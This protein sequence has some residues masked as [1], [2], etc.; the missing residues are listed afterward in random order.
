MCG[1]YGALVAGLPDA[2]LRER[3]QRTFAN[4]R[5]RG[6]DSWGLVAVT[7]DGT[8]ELGRSPSGEG[9]PDL[10][11]IE[12]TWPLALIGLRRAEPTTEW[13]HA[14]RDAD[15]QPFRSPGGWV[16]CHNGTI[17]NDRALLDQLRYHPDFYEPDTRVDS[18]VIGVALDCLGWQAAI[19]AL[20]GAF[21][22]LAARV[23][24]PGALMFA[25]NY[26]PMFAQGT[27]SGDLIQIASQRHFF[28]P[29]DSPLLDPQP[30]ELPP[31]SIGRVTS[32][33]QL[34]L[35]SLYPRRPERRRVLALCSGGLDCAVAAWKHHVEGDEVTLLH[36]DYGCRAR[37][38]ERAAVERLAERIG[39]AP[40][41][42][43]TD[44]FTRRARS[45]LTAPELEVQA[46]RGGEGAAELGAEWVP[47]RNTVFLAL[48]LAY[49][50]AHDFDTITLG[51]NLEESSGGYPDNEQEFVNKVAELIPYA[52]RPYRRVDLSQ[53]CGTLMKPEIVR[54]GHELG[55]PLELTWSCYHGGDRHCGSCGPCWM[56]QVA[57][58][59]NGLVD[60]VFGDR[61]QEI[62]RRHGVR[63]EAPGAS[64]LSPA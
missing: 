51:T 33:G 1:V 63:R 20:E 8:I 62:E 5:E 44:F 25:T 14:P 19:G 15:V 48:A 18:G 2:S 27:V 28:P 30:V 46:A 36:V 47:A 6:R 26:K 31:Y 60:P 22:I 40:V 9:A 53:P 11:A 64:I 42:L 24:D 13:V 52:L 7:D 61:W 43:E 10:S 38:R 49:A 32:V 12:P 37:V 39:R 45:V 4:A 57:Y 41:V 21:A 59:I 29:T 17:A 58:L 50:E 55:A 3:V 34:K 35:E 16:Y 23:G 56:R 54:L